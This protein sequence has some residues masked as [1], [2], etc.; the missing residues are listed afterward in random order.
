MEGAK[1]KFDNLQDRIFSTINQ[2]YS[3]ALLS[4]SLKQIDTIQKNINAFN[5]AATKVFNSRR[6]ADQIG[7]LLAGTYSLFSTKEIDP[8]EAEEWIRK[9]EDWSDH[10]TIGDKSDPER[11]L[12]RIC[13][14][15]VVISTSIGMMRPTIGE[16]VLRVGVQGYYLDNISEEQADHELRRF[17]IKVEEQ[18][19]FISNNSD[20][21][22]SI[23]RDTPWHSNWSRPLSELNG[24]ERTNNKYFSPGIKS[25]AIVL[26]LNLISD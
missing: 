18:N 26:P 12:D 17:G 21:I 24:A 3:E 5:I 25:R 20:P 16:L 22:R 6:I 4:R 2:E 14:H 11:L 13:T 15:R 8:K 19:V 23:L 9:H 7:T 10:T 1:D